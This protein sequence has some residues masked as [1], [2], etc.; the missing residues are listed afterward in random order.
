MPYRDLGFVRVGDRKIARLRRR[1]L[2]GRYKSNLEKL[3]AKR[4]RALSHLRVN[5]RIPKLAAHNLAFF[6]GAGVFDFFG[7][8]MRQL[9]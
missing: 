8:G 5:R 4:R 7:F 2:Q 3:K 9:L 1:P 6:L